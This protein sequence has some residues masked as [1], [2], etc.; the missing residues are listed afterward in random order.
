MPRAEV[1]FASDP[2]GS[3]Q[4]PRVLRAPTGPQAD[5]RDYWGAGKLQYDPAGIRVPV[6][7]IVGEWDADTPP[8]MAQALFPRLS[9]APYK[10]LVMIGEG[11]HIVYTE[12]NR[13]Q[14]FREVQLFLDEKP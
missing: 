14:L 11:T 8:S 5:N 1:A 3:G 6:L 9:N 2:W 12:K 10:R 13:L 4:N 7:L